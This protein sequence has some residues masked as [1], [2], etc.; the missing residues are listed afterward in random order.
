M[1]GVSQKDLQKTMLLVS[2]RGKKTRTL[3]EVAGP[4]LMIKKASKICLLTKETE[5]RLCFGIFRQFFPNY[6]YYGRHNCI[7]R[8]LKYYLITKLRID[9]FSAFE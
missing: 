8:L 6:A 9:H 2:K 4:Y 1:T 5:E 3:L 7:M